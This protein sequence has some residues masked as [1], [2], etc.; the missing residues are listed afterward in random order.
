VNAWNTAVSVVGSRA[1]G[2]CNVLPPLL[3]GKGNGR[4]QRVL[5][6]LKCVV[7]IAGLCL[8]AALSISGERSSGE[9]LV[10]ACPKALAIYESGT[11]TLLHTVPLPDKPSPRTVSLYTDPA[12]GQIF[13]W[14]STMQY[15]ES[16]PAETDPADI[17]GFYSLDPEAGTLSAPLPI[18]DLL[19]KVRL[20][21][22]EAFLSDGRWLLSSPTRKDWP[23]PIG[24]FTYDPRTGKSEVFPL[25]W[26]KSEW[27]DYNN[28][29]IL[30]H[31]ETGH[32]GVLLA[33]KHEPYHNKR[34]IEYDAP[35][36]L[37]RLREASVELLNMWFAG[38]SLAGKTPKAVFWNAVWDERTFDTTYA[39][40][41]WDWG[42]PRARK[43]AENKCF[44]FA[45]SPWSGRVWF[46]P[47]PGAGRNCSYKAAQAD[48]ISFLSY[49][50]VSRKT[51][52]GPE[53]PLPEMCDRLPEM[54]AASW[55]RVRP[56]SQR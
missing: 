11:G 2:Y 39:L 1:G 29:Q 48:K 40:Y 17:Q 32:I 28:H 24:F 56:R 42:A 10:V 4:E 49:D 51:G 36:R 22:F 14:L 26:G 31:P 44:P 52:A 47:L 46:A 53:A 15:F 27:G 35:P 18:D 34:F 25:P 23:Q 30:V 6:R 12:S 19:R 21:F 9:L 50:L 38:W 43:I 55:A 5:R 16:Y 33:E 41:E 20:F 13:V 45:V 37:R 54:Y 8:L 3:P 7:R